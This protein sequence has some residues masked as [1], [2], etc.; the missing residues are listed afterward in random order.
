MK[1]LALACVLVFIVY[2]ISQSQTIT[3]TSPNGGENW[4]L[5]SPHNITWRPS[6]VRGPAGRSVQEAFQ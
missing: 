2:G 1:K 5:G 4:A 3:V 6:G